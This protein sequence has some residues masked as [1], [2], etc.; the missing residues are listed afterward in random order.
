MIPL[1]QCTSRS[2]PERFLEEV[3]GKSHGFLFKPP[4]PNCCQRLYHFL[5]SLAITFL[6]LR[7]S[8][9]SHP[10]E[11]Y[12]LFAYIFLL[13]FFLFCFILSLVMV[14]LH[15]GIEVI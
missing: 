1:L 6:I 12:A 14:D 5:P 11:A 9:Y 10:R 15:C 7:Q 4:I 3:L 2:T 13:L 8:D